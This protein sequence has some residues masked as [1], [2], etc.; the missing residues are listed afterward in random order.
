MPE[1][2]PI[3]TMAQLNPT[4]GNITDNV[5][6]LRD[7]YREAL[8]G[9]AILVVTPQFSLTG[10]PLRDLAYCPD[11]H[12]AVQA[13]LEHLARL[14]RGTKTALL[15]GGPFAEDGVVHNGAFLLK[16]GAVTIA[17]RHEWDERS[18]MQ[19]RDA[20]GLVDLDTCK[21][22]VLLGGAVNR[23][24]AASDLVDR[25]AQVLVA[26]DASQFRS[27]RIESRVRDVAMNRV[28]DN[29]V[30]LLYV[31]LVGGQDE[32]VYDGG[33]FCMDGQGRMVQK[34]PQFEECVA[35]WDAGAPFCPEGEPAFPDPM[36]EMWRA[37]TTALRDYVHK[38]GFTDVMVGL[39]GGIDSAL[40]AAVAADALGAEHV[41]A[42]RLP[43]QYTSDLSN[44]SAQEM[45][46]IW[47]FS[48][49][50]VAI[51]GVVDAVASSLSGIFPDG[52]KKLTRENMQ[53]RARGYIL[54]TISN[55]NN[56][57][58][59]ATGNKSEGATGYATLYGDMC[60]VYNPIKDVWKTTVFSLAKWRN[61]NKPADAK[62]PEGIVIPV[63]IIERPPSAEL[64][65][66]Q[67]DSDSLPAYPILDGVLEEIIEHHTAEK[68]IVAKGFDP[69][70]VTRVQRLLK[71]TEYKRRQACPGLAMTTSA[72]I[73]RS[74][75]IVNKFS[76]E[77]VQAIKEMPTD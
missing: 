34:L 38:S 19:G 53:A 55:E 64:S 30:P 66:G 32:V 51:S 9:E 54:M 25:G 60:G 36:E 71:N 45:A 22:G 50:T 56:W 43:G 63:E 37:M 15:V 42:F 65:P 18:D 24:D 2:D 73:F 44:S 12:A 10:A 69:A 58:H 70:V 11:L 1:S 8:S 68:D 17:A 27:R 4:V 20:V 35:D 67:L 13:A 3:I 16:D 46:D 52:L 26:M 77:M 14:T 48:L 21:V 6:V 40:V 72:F 7:T 33:S 75:P 57:L 5:R 31:N 39:S 49:E 59:L 76:P 23:P 28:A 29:C 47:G 61:A 41:H 74:L 62:G